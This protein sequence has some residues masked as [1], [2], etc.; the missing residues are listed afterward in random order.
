M[1]TKELIE[2]LKERNTLNEFVTVSSK[3]EI[4]EIVKRLE[5][6]DELKRVVKVYAKYDKTLREII[7]EWGCS[8]VLQYIT[9]VLL[10]G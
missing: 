4:K 3:E 2:K 10:L 8:M 6:L 9:G 1:T 7:K 5:E